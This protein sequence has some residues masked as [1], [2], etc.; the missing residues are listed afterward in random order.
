[1]DVTVPGDISSAAFWMVA[2]AIHPDAELTIK[3]VGVNPTRSGVITAL[4]QMGAD[5]TVSGEREVAGEPV[6]DITVRSSRL[7]GTTISG[8]LVPLLIDEIP[9]LAVAAA[10]AEGETRVRD[11]RELVVKESNR[12][13]S[14]VDWLTAA[15]VKVHAQQDGMVIEGAGRLRGG[16]FKSSGDHRL[17]MSLGVAGLVAEGEL[18]VWDG[19][20]AAKSYPGFWEEL[21]RLGG[22]AG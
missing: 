19:E 7:R 12:L 15:G 8:G 11:A 2:A 13:A 16:D 10:M 6:A 5:L 9:V 17:A 14:T 4:K 21:R 1:V 22:L 18:R 3:D 20:A